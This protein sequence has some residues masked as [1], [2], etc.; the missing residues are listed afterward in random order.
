MPKEGHVFFASSPAFQTSVP[1]RVDIDRRV[2]A[3]YDDEE[4]ALASGYLNQPEKLKGRAALVE[5]VWGKGRIVLFGFR[6]QHRAQSYGTFKVLFNAILLS[7]AERGK[8]P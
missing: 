5:V 2:V 1:P 4:S 3:R 7:T 6:P 8:L